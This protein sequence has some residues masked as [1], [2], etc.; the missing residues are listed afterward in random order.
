MSRLLLQASAIVLGYERDNGWQ[1]V[2]ENFDLQLAKGEIVSILGPSGVGKSSLLRVLAGLQVPREGTVS[3]LG[4]PLQGP[5]PRVAVAFQ[6]PSLLPWL[7]LEKNVAFGLDFAR[8]PQLTDSERQGRIDQ[9]I[10]EVG[11]EHARSYYPAQLSGGMAQRTALARCLARQPQVLLLD[12]PFGALDEV[13][14]TDMQQLLLRVIA[15][16]GTAALLITHD[17]DEALLLSDRILL[18]GNTPARV[19]GEWRI[20]LPQPRAELVDELGALRIDILKTL[21][22][23]SRNPQRHPQSLDLPENGHV[24]G[25]FHSHTS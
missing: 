14:R 25:R 9:A 22:R 13:T 21:R 12:E 11:L 1:N 18:L 5:H 6:D 20:Q 8:Q 2:L 4:E 19:L 3:L 23:A 17:I 7:N 16:H 10:G 24:P 15:R